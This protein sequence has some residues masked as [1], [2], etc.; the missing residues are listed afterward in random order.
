MPKKNSGSSR[1]KK[2]R[3]Q[4]SGTAGARQ[5]EAAAAESR[6]AS[7]EH[8]EAGVASRPDV[9]TQSSFRKK[10]PAKHERLST[11]AILETLKRHKRDK[12]ESLDLFGEPQRPMHD[13]VPRLGLIES[14]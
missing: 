2:S 7:Y 3:S 4:R 6:S 12:Q 5:A 14:R 11:Q 8:P 10:K 13:R 9:V 1:P